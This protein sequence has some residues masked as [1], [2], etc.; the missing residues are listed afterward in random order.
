MP[1][2]SVWMTLVAVMLLLSVAQAATI[3]NP[4]TMEAEAWQCFERQDFGCAEELFRQL[5]AAY[6]GQEPYRLGLAETLFQQDEHTRAAEALESS[7]DALSA[8]AEALLLRIYKDAGVSAYE[9][10][11]FSEAQ[12]MLEKALALNPQDMQAAELAAWAAY[13]QGEYAAAAK[14]FQ[15]V[16]TAEPTQ[17]R[18]RNVLLVFSAAGDEQ[19]RRRFLKELAASDDAAL[20]KT[21]ADEYYAQGRTIRAAAVYD[22]A[23]VPYRNCDAPRIESLAYVR[24][25]DGDEGTSRLTEF[26]VQT[27]FRD[28]LSSGR[29][30]FVA[31]TPMLL[32]AGDGPDRPVAGSYY[33]FVDDNDTAV[34]EFEDPVYAVMP[35]AGFRGEGI[36]SYE[37]RIGTTPIGG[38]VDPAPTY[39]ARIGDPGS[40]YLEMHQC[41]VADSVLS[42]T[43]R[44]DPYG[45]ETWGRVLKNGLSGG[46]SFSLTERYWFSMSAGYD[47]YWGENVEENQSWTMNTSVG[48][49]FDNLTAGLSATVM[50]YDKN[51]DYHTFGHGGYFSPELFLTAG[52]FVDYTL[53]EEGYYIKGR[54]YAGYSHQETAAADRYVELDEHLQGLRQAAQDDL[55]IEYAS[56]EKSEFAFSGGISGMKYLTDRWALGGFGDFSVSEDSWEWSAG[57]MLSYA[58]G[59][60]NGPCRVE[61]LPRRLTVCP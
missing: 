35:Q 45:D 17:D 47:Y 10:K 49:N 38:A 18:A 13:R 23:D 50:H 1:V 52:P 24:E 28:G 30:W 29:E 42:Y 12:A 41:S 51:S 19:A 56:D 20:Q 40:R 22:G 58:F 2:K 53:R 48:G 8:E 44:D 21:A 9:A 16:Y 14:H 25:K 36:F 5:N 55:A 3:E 15:T 6:P 59:D 46:L 39:F 7:P 33:R 32:T 26:G 27:M 61:E 31:I 34:N 60:M 57:L 4:G 37:I 54:L 11:R 43:G